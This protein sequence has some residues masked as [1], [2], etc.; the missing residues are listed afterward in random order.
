MATRNHLQRIQ[1]WLAI[2]MAGLVLSGV[3]A[4]QSRG[5]NAVA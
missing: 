1:I 3:T 4:F 2:F 5:L